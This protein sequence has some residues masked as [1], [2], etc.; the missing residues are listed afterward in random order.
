MIIGIDIGGTQTRLTAV[1]V[2]GDSGADRVIDTAA[3]GTPR[4]FVEWTEAQVRQT[5]GRP[6]SVGVAVPGPLDARLGVLIN[7][8]NLPAWTGAPLAEMIGDALGCPVH[9]EDDANL[10]AYGEHRRG[11]GRGV[12][13]MAYVTWS[14]GVGCGLILGGRLY[15]GAHG[16][17]GEIGHTV[18]DPDGPL[19]ACGQRGCV[20]VFCGG[21]ALAEQTGIAAVELFGAAAAGDAGALAV[22]RRAATYMGH[23]LVNLTNLIDPGVIVIGGG[24]A[25]SWTQVE[26]VLSGVL[27]GSAFI[28]P[29]RRPELRRA[30]LGDRAGLVGA[31]EWARTRLRETC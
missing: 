6:V 26:P 18:L 2:E 11:A 22:V 9:V 5:G 30:E 29:D 24:V 10:A 15:S 8:P 12:P 1:A 4:G 3:L 14:T 7:P 20:E 19:D 13:D 16:T 25:R 21:R 28:T 23:A 31:V 17:A 27:T